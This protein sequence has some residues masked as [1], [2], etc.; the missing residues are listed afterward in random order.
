MEENLVKRTELQI[1][2]AGVQTINVQFD[3]GSS[4]V[5]SNYYPEIA[6]IAQKIKGNV[7]IFGHTDNVGKIEYNQ[8]LSQSRAEAV[9]N[10][11][12]NN[13]GIPASQ[14]EAIGY[15]MT[16]PI[17]DNSTAAG[18]KKNRR[19]EMVVGGDISNNIAKDIISF[20]F[21]DNSS[22]NVDDISLVL[23]DST[24][25]W[26]KD[27]QPQ[28][29]DRMKAYIKKLY[30]GE[31][32]IDEISFSGYP[33]IL[34]IKAISAPPSGSSRR[35]QKSKTW[36]KVTLKQILNDI[37]KK[38]G[39]KPLYEVKRTVKYDRKD[40]RDESDLSFL[41]KL[42][43]DQAYKLKVSDS[44]LIIFDEDESEKAPAQFTLTDKDIENYT[45][46][47]QS[48]D[49][50]TACRVEYYDEDE[51]EAHSYTYTSNN[52]GMV[53]G[54]TLIIKKR[55]KSLAEAKELA[56]RSLRNKNKN[57]TIATFTVSNN[58]DNR[59]FNATQTFNIVG[60]G[61]YDGK[62]II[63]KATHSISNGYKIQIEA[64]KVV[65]I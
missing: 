51:K 24:K 54:Q 15:G 19:I 20:T 23:Q 6:R 49:L 44:M 28:K 8:Q 7:S 5:K 16:R 35:E 59:L 29:G 25:K 42:C 40:Q 31:F 36:E 26:I 3:T 47:T 55:V 61:M 56:E 37:A 1:F 21:T 9:K 57:E 34:D 46:K 30:C 64:H 50:Y 63:D 14:I 62:Y 39:Y 53:T 2:Y 43:E 65:I 22:D 45:L 33:M 48:H 52:G 38:D 58:M 11:L 27:W 18:R 32:E 41:K 12:V 13:H 60:F 17:A 4:V 10:I